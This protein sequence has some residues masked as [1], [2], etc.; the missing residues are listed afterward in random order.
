M[1]SPVEEYMYTLYWNDSNDALV[2]RPYPSKASKY[3]TEAQFLK[4]S[5]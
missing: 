1:T 3:K 2:A 5:F 4:D